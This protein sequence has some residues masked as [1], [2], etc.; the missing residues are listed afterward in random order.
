MRTLQDNIKVDMNV[1]NKTKKKTTNSFE[2]LILNE[3][4]YRF[5]S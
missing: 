1:I 2:K 3:E 4:L 5:M